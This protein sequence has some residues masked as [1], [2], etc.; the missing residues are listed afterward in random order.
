MRRDEQIRVNELLLQ[1]ED[2]FLRIHAAETEV[3]RILGEAFPFSVPEL[4]STRRG[5]RKASDTRAS[6]GTAAAKPAKSPADTL[7]RLE[8]GETGYRVT[9]RQF[10]KVL[11]EDHHEFDAVRTLLACQGRNLEVQ[12]IQTI[13]AD[14]TTAAPLFGAQPSE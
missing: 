8:D 1:R 13:A 3:N 11:V 5:K 6:S 2:L 9:Y 12:S 10:S 7:R 14:G 4:P